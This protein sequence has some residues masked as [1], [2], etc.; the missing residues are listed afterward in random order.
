[1]VTDW[2]Y[3]GNDVSGGE[4]PSWHK[5]KN[6][7]P[8]TLCRVRLVW[9]KEFTASVNVQLGLPERNGTLIP[10]GWH[11]QRMCRAVPEPLIMTDQRLNARVQPQAL[12]CTITLYV[13]GYL[14]DGRNLK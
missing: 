8:A 14:G 11:N 12:Q 2:V 1:M 4:N 3:H 6:K 5:Q 7:G 10:H 13:V 9:K